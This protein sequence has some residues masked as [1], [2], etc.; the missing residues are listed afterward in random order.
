MNLWLT[1]SDALQSLNDYTV[2]SLTTQ[3]ETLDPST[4]SDPIN[5]YKTLLEDAQMQ[6]F[7]LSKQFREIIAEK[8]TEIKEWKRRCAEIS[9]EEVVDD[10]FIYHDMVK[11]E[12]ENRSLKET[13][14]ELENE[15]KRCYKERN[16]SEPLR[17]RSLEMMAECKDLRVECERLRQALEKQSLAAES[18]EAQLTRE[19][20]ELAT[21][22]S[23]LAADDEL[24]SC[25]DALRI[26]DLEIK[27][28]VLTI[29]MHALEQS[30]KD[31]TSDDA[32]PQETSHD[33]D[34]T[35]AESNSVGSGGDS[36]GIGGMDAAFIRDLFYYVSVGNVT[37]HTEAPTSTPIKSSALNESDPNVTTV[38]QDGIFPP[39]TE[40]ETAE[41]EATL[42]QM[43]CE[44]YNL[45]QT[46]RRL[47]E[48]KKQTESA[49]QQFF[50][51]LC[52]W[53]KYIKTDFPALA[54]Q[55]LDN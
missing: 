42:A 28:E 22:Y 2:S 1:A 41:M 13:V 31:L 47:E 30:I 23:K 54:E 48:E 39:P 16:E 3:R 55:Y 46:V 14:E 37:K 15:L 52:S 10:S 5:V 27:N 24:R 9:G 18:S 49:V 50:E 6:H 25:A 34:T 38:S 44:V 43:H 36:T 17:V 4:S 8:D 12:A 35:S 40:A 33:K 11:Y 21:E 19:L 45:K 7:H 32:P 53:E 51:L 29:K 20:E 26:K